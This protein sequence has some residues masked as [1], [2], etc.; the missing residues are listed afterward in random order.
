VNLSELPVVHRVEGEGLRH[1]IEHLPDSRKV[2]QHLV[3]SDVR[4]DLKALQHRMS[5]HAGELLD[6]VRDELPE[7]MGQPKECR[8][9][10]LAQI[11]DRKSTRLN[12]SHVKSSYAVFCLK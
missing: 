1:A 9:A 11:R 5:V 6:V 4:L 3:A 8:V 7:R 10:R 12:S 2:Q